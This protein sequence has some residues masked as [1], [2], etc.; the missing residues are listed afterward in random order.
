MQGSQTEPILSKSAQTEKLRVLR[1]WM[2]KVWLEACGRT[3]K[4]GLYDTNFKWVTT[5]VSASGLL[6]KYWSINIYARSQVSRSD[7]QMSP[8]TRRHADIYL[9]F[10]HMNRGIMIPSVKNQYQLVHVE[11]MCGG[12]TSIFWEDDGNNPNSFEI[13]SLQ[14]KQGKQQLYIQHVPWG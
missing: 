14:S 13:L 2:T 7:Y 5:C 6:E 8:H 9:L 1:S 11:C 3:E 12:K 10:F 4:Q